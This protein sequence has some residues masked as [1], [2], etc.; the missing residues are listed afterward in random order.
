[1]MDRAT[2]LD[3]VEL[4]SLVLSGAYGDACLVVVED[5]SIILW[6]Q[7]CAPSAHHIFASGSTSSA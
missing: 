3:S 4:M 1:M 7:L 6:R 5:K 2:Y